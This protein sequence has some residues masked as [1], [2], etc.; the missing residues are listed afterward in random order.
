MRVRVAVSNA[1]LK[2]RRI[3]FQIGG[4]SSFSRQWRKVFVMR[5][6]ATFSIYA[7][8]LYNP[9]AFQF[10]YL[11]YGIL[12]PKTDKNYRT[13]KNKIIIVQIID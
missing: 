11:I 1:L 7:G 8:M 13:K 9:G 10:L 4:I 2:F 5:Y 6:G 12:S 3:L